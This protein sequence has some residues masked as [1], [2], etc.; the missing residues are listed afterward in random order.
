[1]LVDAHAHCRGPLEEGD[2]WEQDRLF[3]EAMDAVGIDV[4]VVSNLSTPRPATA[5]GFEKCNR[6]MLAALK[7]FRGRLWGY[8][9]VNPGYTKEALADIERCL[10]A[11]E[12][13][14]GVK[15]YNEYFITM[16]VL[17]LTRLP[18]SLPS[19]RRSPISRDGSAV[20]LRRGANGGGRP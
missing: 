10:E 6:N 17:R 5:E 19:P 9:Y 12:D 4:A 20:H 18:R 14:V 16:V 11:D 1:M 13:C 2:P 7:E 3:V 15:L 8:A